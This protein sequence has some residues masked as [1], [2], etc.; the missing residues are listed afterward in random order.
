M[1]IKATKP[2]IFLT[3]NVPFNIRIDKIVNPD[4]PCNGYHFGSLIAH[5]LIE[6]HHS[7]VKVGQTVCVNA[8]FGSNVNNMINLGG[9]KVRVSF[10]GGA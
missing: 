1:F 9:S 5:E 4:S 2:V 3:R 7:K 8:V 10:Y 6:K